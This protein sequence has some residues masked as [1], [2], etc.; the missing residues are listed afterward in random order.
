MCFPTTARNRVVIDGAL[1]AS[2]HAWGE[3]A[4]ALGWLAILALAVAWVLRQLLRSAA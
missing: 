1:S 4:M 2:S 3:L